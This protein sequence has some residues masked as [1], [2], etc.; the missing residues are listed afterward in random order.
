MP[1][2][3]MHAVN[4]FSAAVTGAGVTARLI[5]GTVGAGVLVVA[6]E[7][8]LLD[9]D[10][11]AGFARVLLN[12]RRADLKAGW[13]AACACLRVLASALVSVVAFAARGI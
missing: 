11:R 12:E 3:R 10:E 5:C 4:R 8:V 1:C 2:E 6:G 7:P 9:P 13:Q